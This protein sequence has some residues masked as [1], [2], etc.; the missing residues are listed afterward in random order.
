MPG[1]GGESCDSGVHTLWLFE[2]CPGLE[3]GLLFLQILKRMEVD[4]KGDEYG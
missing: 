1:V 2:F 3:L 4:K